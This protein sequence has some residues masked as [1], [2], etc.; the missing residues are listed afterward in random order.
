[1]LILQKIKLN[2]FLSHKDT[3]IVFRP[4]Q[5]LLID[6]MSGSG[7]SSLVDALVWCLYNQARVDNKSLIRRGTK[8]ADV[9]VVLFDDE[10]N[11]EYKISRKITDK[12]KHEF[13][14]MENTDGKSFKPIKAMGLKGTQDYLENNILHASYLLFINS[15][16]Y[17]QDNSDTFV[18]Q[19]ATKKKDII[20]EIIGSSNYD[21]YLKKTKEE[22]SSR[23]IDIEVV[24]ARIQNK[25]RA[26]DNDK[27]LVTNLPTYLKTK[28]KLNNELII[29]EENH[30]KLL[31]SQKSIIEKN[32]LFKNK[33]DRLLS[34]MEEINNNK[35]EIDRLNKKIIDSESV[36]IENIK[37]QVEVLNNKRG[38]LKVYDGVQQEYLGWNNA[39]M[40]LIKASP[41]ERD[42]E[43]EIGIIN[44]KMIQIIKE[45]IEVC[46]VIHKECPILKDKQ[47]ARIKELE[48]DLVESQGKNKQLSE[49]KNAHV[50]KI[51]LLGDKPVVPEDKIIKIKQEI[52]SLESFETQLAEYA[53]KK[54]IL[55]EANL[56]LI[57][58]NKKQESL[59]VESETIGKEIAGRESIVKEEEVINL[60]LSTCNNNKNKLNG[61]L[62]DNN[63]YLMMAER[64]V[65]STKA[66]KEDLK[67]FKDGISNTK[68]EIEA[69]DLLKS[70]L[71]PNGIKA[72]VIDYLIPKLEES[73][74]RILGKLSD[75]SVKLDTQK[76]GIRKETVLDGLF[77]TVI[78]PEGLEMD[79]DSFSGGEK[80]KIST[81]INESLAEISK[82]S[83]RI[84]DE[85][86]LSLDGESTEKFIE[87]LIEIQNRVNQ[88]ICISHI[89]E[90][91][92][93]FDEKI[94]VVKIGG[95]SRVNK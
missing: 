27:E 32:A 62:S 14:V 48:T 49:D 40:E 77:I 64:A 5:R 58:I 90:I 37:S 52:L 79:F 86:I 7:K 80:V 92:S 57:A 85:S 91:K 61:E 10:N 42:F 78:N 13:S 17:I 4:N 53:N 41:V 2:N 24:N 70:A 95:I 59:K 83:F 89:Q 94:E 88:T 29:V 22:L 11:T 15:I 43:N 76:S 55:D 65:E 12:N 63:G 75:F 69:L 38:E 71:G 45:E 82:I 33:E 60:E 36:D 20:L 8:Y 31:N 50:K 87:T 54:I 3:E 81:A 28:D 23:K 51:E 30:K 73:I 66:N 34:V 1:M 56:S 19:T 9:T 39:M 25:E 26:I 84:L 74:N 35:V 44:R 67:K 18:K 16:V 72:T 6:G 47:S 21:D 68:K 46:P 93:I